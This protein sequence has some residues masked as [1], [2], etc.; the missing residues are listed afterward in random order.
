MVG[1]D[2]DLL[3]A[4]ENLF[5]LAGR[6]TPTD[7]LAI[8][9]AVKDV[10]AS[11]GATNATAITA[12]SIAD[13]LQ[14]IVELLETAPVVQPDTAG[15]KA[16][17]AFALA[18]SVADTVEYL[19]TGP[20]AVQYPVAGGGGATN[21]GWIPSTRT[22]T[23]DTGADA[24]ITLVTA[25]DAGLAPASGGGTVNFLRADATWASPPSPPATDLSW[26]AATRVIA[27]STGADATLT[28]ATALLDGLMAAADKA[29]LDTLLTG[30]AIVTVPNARFEHEETIAVAGILP[31]HRITAGIGAHI[32]SDE[33]AADLLDLTGMSATA[34]TGSILFTLGFS[35]PTAGPIRIN[36]SAS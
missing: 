29:K 1:N 30:Q 2:P 28:L 14:N 10:E 8:T 20:V 33:N 26:D 23:S 6:D 3:R 36:W 4:I 5:A 31:A 35:Q 34:G 24:V 27:S 18:T 21:L 22:V 15:A 19:E 17:A 12:V 13:R 32:D 11:L 9:N 7:L 25:T 16:D